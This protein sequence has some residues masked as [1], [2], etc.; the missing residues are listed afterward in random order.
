MGCVPNGNAPSPGDPA[1]KIEGRLLPGC[2]PVTG[3]L[4]LEDPALLFEGE[5]EIVS[6]VQYLPV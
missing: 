1:S 3:Q 5:S 6:K 4:A 2:G